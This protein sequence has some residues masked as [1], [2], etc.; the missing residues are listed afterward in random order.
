MDCLRWSY[1]PALSSPIV[2][3]A[4]EGWNDAGESA[5]SALT[6]MADR[7]DT[8]EFAEIDAEEFFD[9]TA[10]R[11]HVRFED[12]ER[13]ID[14][15]STTLSHGTIPG[16]ERDVILVH[17]VEPSLRWRTFATAITDVASEYGASLVLTLGALLAE[18]AHSRPID[19]VGAS[20]DDE[21]N[22]RLGLRKSTYEGPTGI[23]GVLA[24][25]CRDLG[26]PSASL[27]AAVP[28]YV[29]GAPCPKATLALVQKTSALLDLP[30]VTTDLEIA[31]SAYERQ[32]DELVDDDEETR[33]Y[34]AAIERQQDARH[35][36]DDPLA[37]LDT[38][39]FMEEVERFLREGGD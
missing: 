5:T 23:V 11:P 39:V 37:D 18:V 2:I 24:A 29:P 25:H 36:L 3:A 9:F 6:W 33:N 20:A 35:E 4:F 10:T 17:G 12:G 26:I 27:W 19:I 16:T 32:I 21:L 30:A 38:E 28:S 1:R 8:D 14:W 31:A 34:V 7:W 15:P 13:V 22:Q